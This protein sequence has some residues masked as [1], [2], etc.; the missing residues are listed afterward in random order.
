ME[1]STAQPTTSPEQPA[2][3]LSDDW[4]ALRAEVAERRAKLPVPPA[5]PCPP[6]R[7]FVSGSLCGIPRDGTIGVVRERLD[8]LQKRLAH[9]PEK[10]VRVHTLA[11][12]EARTRTKT[13]NGPD[14]VV[15]VELK[16]PIGEPNRGGNGKRTS[17]EER[18]KRREE[19]RASS[20]MVD[21]VHVPE[22]TIDFAPEPVEEPKPKGKTTWKGFADVTSQAKKP[23]VAAHVYVGSEAKC[24]DCHYARVNRVHVSERTFNRRIEA[25]AEAAKPH[26]A[27]PPPVVLAVRKHA[28]KCYVCKDIPWNVRGGT[29]AACGLAR[30]DAP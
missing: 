23:P 16:K 5:P 25:A 9:K 19:Y 29:C 1:G 22:F 13:K 8:I 7:K 18:A 11:W 3:S 14:K 10:A 27:E 2:A 24:L 17:R 15:D 28:P 30:K 6:P 26:I 12:R 21:K 4:D 20:K